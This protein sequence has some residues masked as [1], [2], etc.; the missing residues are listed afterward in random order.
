M[1][2]ASLLPSVRVRARISFEV[3]PD[4]GVSV[5]QTLTETLILPDLLKME[6]LGPEFQARAL[7][8]HI[9]RGFRKGGEI[10][11]LV[12]PSLS[13]AILAATRLLEEQRRA[14]DPRCPD[15]QS[16]ELTILPDLGKGEGV[17]CRKCGMVH[18]L[19]DCKRVA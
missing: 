14:A 15:C 4:A 13:S 8:T 9:E 19:S 17:I 7:L 6:A 12:L 5:N 3:E 16:D 10:E 11:Q 18:F 2:K 1:S